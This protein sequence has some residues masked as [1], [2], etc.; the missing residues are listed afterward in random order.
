MAR[1]DKQ[2]IQYGGFEQGPIRPPSEAYSLLIRVT[3]NC[4]WNRCT[5][6][7]VYKGNR[8]SLRPVEHVKADI[9]EVYRHV[10]TII[11]LA[12]EAGQIRHS[13]IRK[14]ME[15]IAPWDLQPFYAAHNWMA[16]GMRSIFLQDA[17]S[18]IIKPS[19]LVE[20]LNHLMKRF[21]E[22][23]RITSYARSHTIARMKDG[24]LKAIREAG[25]NR[26]RGQKL[27]AIHALETADALNKIN[28]DFIRLRTLALPEGIPLYEDYRAGR[29]EKCPELMVTKE[30]YQFIENLDGITS[31]VIS[32]H[33]LNLFQEVEGK[34]PEDKSRML[35]V[36]Q[37]FLDM[38]PEQQCLYQVGRRL[39]F[40]SGF[41]DM[42]NPHLR[43]RAEQRRDKLGI[44]PE[45]VDQVL[46]EVTKRFV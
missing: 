41:S 38:A 1:Q 10:K 2:Q 46:T 6:C 29:F 40:F 39:G 14:A 19:D 12:D 4:P 11:E 21:P 34:L 32:D 30:I 24:D 17:N 8:F 43:K 23:E 15:N 45:N 35:G 37:A 16:G 22:V 27:S 26:I 9:D 42:D 36:L 18:L 33:I 31:T 5:F 28:P 25:L 20:I 3:R 7:S 44:T 13:D